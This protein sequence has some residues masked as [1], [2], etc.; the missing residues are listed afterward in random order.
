M[1]IIRQRRTRQF[2]PTADE[3]FMVNNLPQADDQIKT[4][5]TTHE[6]FK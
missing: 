5:K 1:S 4:I 3:I 2:I 6:K